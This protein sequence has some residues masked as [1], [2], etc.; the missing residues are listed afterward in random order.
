MQN[1]HPDSIE[2]QGNSRTLFKAIAQDRF[3][4]CS[5]SG[6]ARAAAV[7][8][9]LRRRLISKSDEGVYS[10]TEAGQKL[11]DAMSAP[12]VD[13]PEATTAPSEATGEMSTVKTPKPKKRKGPAF[14]KRTIGYVKAAREAF[15]ETLARFSDEDIARVAWRPATVE[16][17]LAKVRAELAG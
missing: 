7:Y 13:A 14:N 1:D 6:P 4:T 2:V 10:L 9:L 11:Y 8:A 16:K 3:A 12:K 17:A 5:V 15:G